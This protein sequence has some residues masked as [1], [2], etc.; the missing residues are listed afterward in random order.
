MGNILAVASMA[1]QATQIHAIDNKD[2][3]SPSRM[4]QPDHRSQQVPPWPLSSPKRTSSRGSAIQHKRFAGQDRRLAISNSRGSRS[5][6]SQF[7]LRQRP[8]RK[9]I[10]RPRVQTSGRKVCGHREVHRLDLHRPVSQRAREQGL[11]P[12]QHRLRSRRP[13]RYQ[14]FFATIAFGHSKLRDSRQARAPRWRPSVSSW[15]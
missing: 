2:Q 5:R 7:R 10:L 12:I 14:Q 6:Q 3:E 8:N 15:I 9:R 13:T 4:T 11:L 1:D